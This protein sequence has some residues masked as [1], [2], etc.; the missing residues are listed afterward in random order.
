MHGEALRADTVRV[1]YGPPGDRVIDEWREARETQFPY[2]NAH[3]SGGCMAGRPR[4]ARV[5]YCRDCRRTQQAWV[6]D[7]HARHGLAMR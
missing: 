3:V 7:F 2:A 5:M 4:L 1:V 6:A